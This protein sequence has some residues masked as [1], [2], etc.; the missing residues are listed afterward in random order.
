VRTTAAG[1]ALARAIAPLGALIVEGWG[2]AAGALLLQEGGLWLTSR[3]VEPAE[4]RLAR[5]LFLA[6]FILRVLVTLPTH[7]LARL[8]DG[9]GALFQ[10][11]YTNDLV[12]AWLA[13]IAGGDGISIFPGHQHLL[14][15]V[16]PYLIMASYAVFGFAPLVPKLLNCAFG[17][18]SAVLVYDIARRAFN[19]RVAIVAA[20]GATIMPSLVVWSAASL[21]EPLVLFL[22]LLSLRA[23]QTA[24]EAPRRS[25]ALTDALVLLVVT[26]ALALDLRSTLSLILLGVLTIVLLA[27]V[28]LRPWQ[29]AAAGLTIAVLLGG[30]LWIARSRVSD[31]PVSAVAEDVMLQ[32]RHRRAQEAAAAR[33]QIRPELDVV[34][35]TG[36]ALPLAEAASDAAPF[37]VSSDV[38]EPLAF[39]LLAPAPWQAHTLLEL[40]A[41]A[42]TVC[43]LYVLLIAS[44]FGWSAV[45]GRDK[46][47]FVVCLVVF[48]VGNWLVLAVSEGNLGNLVRHRLMLAPTLLIL[49]AAGLEQLWLRAG[50][51]WPR[52]FRLRLPTNAE[53]LEARADS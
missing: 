38:V 23:V 18:L 37:S 40:G 14:E 33:S 47:L 34:T 31:R 28:R 32:I 15:G 9:N 35:A 12:G 48:G 52:T 7:Y 2:A 22:A 4:R 8:G 45:R 53:A 3:L 13:R 50:S 19:R 10:D 36:S 6:V 25:R 20:I 17:A 5:A 43:M 42:E 27:R 49:G 30:G 1:L 21:K 39:A 46:R 44:F 11:D 29:L 51:R 24:I 26:V 16:Y 41:S